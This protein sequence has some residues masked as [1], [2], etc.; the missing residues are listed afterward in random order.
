MGIMQYLEEFMA[1]FTDILVVGRKE[2]TTNILKQ[3]WEDGWMQIEIKAVK[4]GFCT[5]L[6]PLLRSIKTLFQNGRP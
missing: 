5:T 6:E 2:L 4:K 3:A 1:E